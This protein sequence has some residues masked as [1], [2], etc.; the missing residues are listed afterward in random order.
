VK[1][2]CVV[3]DAPAGEAQP[4][5]APAAMAAEPASRPR[6]ELDMIL[7]SWIPG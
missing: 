6:R 7:V 1:G 2:V 5:I 4:V 3:R